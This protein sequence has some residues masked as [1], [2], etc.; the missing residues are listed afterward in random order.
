MSLKQPDGSFI[1]SKHGEVDVRGTYCLLVVATLL[2][3]LTP[4]LVAGTS[5]FISSMQT[6]EGGFASAS[7][8]HFLDDDVLL[9][10]MRP[11]LGEAHGGYTSC[12]LA[13]WAM[14][15]AASDPELP[16]PASSA[17][18]TIDLRRLLRWMALMQGS[19]VEGGGFRGRTNKLVD[20][21]YSWWVGGAFSILES[22]LPVPPEERDQYRQEGN[23]QH[24][25]QYPAPSSS[26]S[27]P[28][29][30]D[31]AGSGPEPEAGDDSEWSDDDH[32][33]GLC[34]KRTFAPM[35]L[36]RSG[37]FTDEFTPDQ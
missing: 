4:E 2:D 34:N 22:L 15:L 3:L 10:H 8:P 30:V 6:Y 31:A 16:D 5:G 12:A 19:E 35:T 11:P 14:L 37:S 24:G 9:D 7:Q 13:S 33:T 28:N 26:S 1:V 17:S 21:C 23:H 20:G 32:M 18:P 27:P 29:T 25:E 36:L